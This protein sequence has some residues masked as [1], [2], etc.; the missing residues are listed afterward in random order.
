MNRFRHFIRL[1]AIASAFFLVSCIDGY[2]EIWLNADGSGRA[3]V[4][5]SIPS[6]AAR[7]QGGESGVREMVE[8]FLKD[9][10]GIKTSSH[11]VTSI[12]GRLNLHVKVTFDSALDLQ[13]ISQSDSIRKLPDSATGLTGVIQVNVSGRSVVVE[14]RLDVGKA[15]PG[16]SLIPISNWDGHGLTYIVHL[17]LAA[18]ESNAGKVTDS[19]K[20]LEWNFPLA[21]AIKGPMTTRFVAPVP[22]PSWLI[23]SVSSMV[24]GISFMVFRAI[25]R[26]NP[27]V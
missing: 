7:F 3:E 21:E 8:K 23:A 15:L 1:L 17:P 11:E 9:A 2:E 6:A 14:R 22:I 25:R 19:G 5:Y 26:K 4:T 10:P 16:S 18:T 13:E 12:D 20:K 27:V 24:L